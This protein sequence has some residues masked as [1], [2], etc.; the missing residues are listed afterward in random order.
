MMSV[1]ILEEKTFSQSAM[2]Q[3]EITSL[4]APFVWK[5]SVWPIGG[6]DGMCWSHRRILVAGMEGHRW[7]LRKAIDLDISSVLS[8]AGILF[9]CAW[10]FLKATEQQERRLG[11]RYS[12]PL[13]CR[14]YSA[15]QFTAL[16]RSSRRPRGICAADVSAYYLL[17]ADSSTT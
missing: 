5:F 4:R 15:F 11:H 13:L 9:H 6:G 2:A 17:V 3:L 7:A 1:I 16:A 8:H 12:V 14:K 10:S